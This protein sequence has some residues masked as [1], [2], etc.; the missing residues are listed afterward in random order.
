MLELDTVICFLN[1]YFLLFLANKVQLGLRLPCFQSHVR[2]SLSES[3]LYAQV[4]KWH[5]SGQWQWRF[6]QIFWKVFISWFLKT[7]K[8]MSDAAGAILWPPLFF[9]PW[10][11]TS[12][13]DFQQL[14]CYHEVTCMKIKVNSKDR[15]IGIC[16]QQ[17]YLA[18]QPMPTAT[19]IQIL[20]N[21]KIKVTFV[22]AIVIGFCILATEHISN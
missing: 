6:L 8:G 13:L 1:T 12:S 11:Q 18:R 3:P 14:S 7:E 15:K 9:L 21:Q 4:A 22:L 5:S 20:L 19:H 17:N 16:N 2:Y 10:R